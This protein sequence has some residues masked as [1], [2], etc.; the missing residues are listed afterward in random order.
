MH[1]FLSLLVLTTVVGA[2]PSPHLLAAKGTGVSL[3]GESVCAGAPTLVLG[4]PR[5]CT[6]AL[7]KRLAARDRD[8][9]GLV[10]ELEPELPLVAFEQVLTTLYRA[11][12]SDFTLRSGAHQRVITNRRSASI[13]T[14]RFRPNGTFRAGVEEGRLEPGPA[15]PK[16]WT[17]VSV[18]L[19]PCLAELAPVRPSLFV[20]LDALPDL[21]RDETRTIAFLWNLLERIDARFA[22]GLIQ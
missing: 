19:E 8:E 16:T 2:E 22:V 1:A 9:R 10:V 21:R 20:D 4:Y 13:V 15:C 11:N 12:L 7:E 5:P 14:L 17:A 18:G 3:D 6:V